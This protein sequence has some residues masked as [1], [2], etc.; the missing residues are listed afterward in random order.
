MDWMNY[1]KRCIQ[2]HADLVIVD[3][4]Y[5]HTSMFVEDSTLHMSAKNV[6]HILIR[7][8]GNFVYL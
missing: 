7:Y 2:C 4:K 5:Q 8:F 6:E 3:L 1:E